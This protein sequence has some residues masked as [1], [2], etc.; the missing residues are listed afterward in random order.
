MRLYKSINTNDAGAVTGKAYIDPINQL[1][2]L[3]ENENEE[4]NFIR[5]EQGV[6]YDISSDLGYIRLR[7]MVMNEII[8]CTFVLEDRNNPGDT[9]LVVGNPAN[10]EGIDLELMMLKPRNSHPN[11]PS[12]DL[13]FKNVYYLGTTQI[14]TE[15]FEVKIINKRSTRV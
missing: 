15:G 11:H 4:G 14:N 5:L 12:W 6:N 10:S 1:D 13:M 8:G 7:D 2:S 3:Y 9:I